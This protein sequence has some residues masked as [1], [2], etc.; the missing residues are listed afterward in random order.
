MYFNTVPITKKTNVTLSHLHFFQ[1]TV[2]ARI[3]KSKQEYDADND[4]IFQVRKDKQKTMHAKPR[5][6]N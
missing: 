6:L 2:A 4:T 1:L 3:L 5:R